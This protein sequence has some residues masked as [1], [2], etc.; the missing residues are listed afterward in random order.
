MWAAGTRCTRA[1]PRRRRAQRAASQ[2]PQPALSSQPAARAASP[3]ARI[4]T[5]SARARAAFIAAA[6]W[7]VWGGSATATVGRFLTVAGEAAGNV[8]LSDGVEK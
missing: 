2:P 4:M 8:E 1:A 5:Q 3:A 7:A 6:A